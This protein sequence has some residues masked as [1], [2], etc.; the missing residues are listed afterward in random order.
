MGMARAEPTRLI[1]LLKMSG[2]RRISMG[3]KTA[4]NCFAKINK[5]RIEEE[6]IRI[7]DIII[8]LW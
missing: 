1:L 3:E 8:Y 4:D 6:V 2:I 5:Y 7:S